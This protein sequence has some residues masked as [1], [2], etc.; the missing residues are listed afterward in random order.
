MWWP[1]TSQLCT[2]IISP[3]TVCCLVC[4]ILFWK[5]KLTEAGTIF[6]CTRGL[7]Y[8][9]KANSLQ[10]SWSVVNW[11]MTLHQPGGCR[12]ALC[13]PAQ[14]NAAHNGHSSATHSPAAHSHIAA[15][16]SSKSTAGHQSSLHLEACKSEE[17]IFFFLGNASF[18]RSSE[19]LTFAKAVS[20][21]VM[22]GRC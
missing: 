19:Y 22:K 8:C 11:S 6:I 17:Q 20:S 2:Q 7:G 9:S 12:H 21:V 5:G 13:T 4:D 16:P 3:P 1:E 14:E 10:L 18:C 15:F